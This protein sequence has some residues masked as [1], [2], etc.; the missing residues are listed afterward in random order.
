VNFARPC[1]DC[2]T[3][4]QQGN[5]CSM[6]KRQAQSKWKEGVPNP[7]LNPAWRKLSALVRA[8]RP[9]CEGCGATGVR[10]TVD[11]LQPISQGGALLAPEHMLRVLCLRCHGKVTKHK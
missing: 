4:T 7:Y 1:L 9:W 6:H 5:R 3:L 8:K 10:L 11:H 2:G